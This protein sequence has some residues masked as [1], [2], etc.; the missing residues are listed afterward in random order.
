MIVVNDSVRSM[1]F[2]TQY[3]FTYQGSLTHL[4]WADKE[5]TFLGLRH[6]TTLPSLQLPC[7]AY[8]HPFSQRTLGEIIFHGK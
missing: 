7:L 5:T 8:T 3:I 2:F 6:A 1:D 4:R